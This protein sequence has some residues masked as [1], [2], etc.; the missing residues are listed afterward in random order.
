MENNVQNSKLVFMFP[1]VGSQYSGMGKDLYEN[2]KLVKE[3]FEEA[4]DI[5]KMSLPELCFND[6]QNHK[7]NQLEYS[8]VALLCQSVATYRACMEEISIKPN[9]YIGYSLGE[10]SALCC[11]GV[12][13]FSDALNIVY[14]RGKIISENVEKSEGTMAWIVGVKSDLLERICKNA[15][16]SNHEVYVSAY[17]SPD[18]STVSGN[19]SSIKYIA[20]Q[21]ESEGGL[22]IPIK[23]KGPFHSPMMHSVSDQFESILNKFEF[24]PNGSQVVSN[25]NALPYVGDKAEYIENLV[26]HLVAPI[27]WEQSIRYLLSNQVNESFEIGPKVVLQHMLELNTKEIQCYSL[28]HM[29]DLSNLKNY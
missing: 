22:V 1:G 4:S 21:V 19:Y 6:T 27:K 12:L 15:Q 2:S 29:S 7:L 28:E 26:N 8:K 16:D 24:T 23:M 25:L 10:Y 18:R 14:Q 13:E 11:A 5:L 17:N 9:Y 20:P 3:T